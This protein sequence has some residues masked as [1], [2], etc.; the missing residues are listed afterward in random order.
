MAGALH[1]ATVYGKDPQTLA[2]YP[3]VGDISSPEISTDKTRADL[4]RATA[5]KF[6]TLTK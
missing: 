4:M 5:A 1:Y 6:A 3:G 2:L